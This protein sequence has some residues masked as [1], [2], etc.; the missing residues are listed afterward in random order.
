GK[1]IEEVTA[2]SPLPDGVF[3]E[4][5]GDG[6][7]GSY[8]ARQN[9][10]SISFTGSTAVGKPLY[11]I[12]AEKLIHVCL[13][14]GGSAPGIIFEDAELEGAVDGLYFSRFGNCGQACDALKRLIVHESRFDEVVNRFKEYLEA[15]KVGDPQDESTEVGPLVAKRQLRLLAAQVRDAIRKG[16][17]VATGGKAPKGLKG[18]YFLPTLLTAVTPNMRVWQEE[19]FG[20]VLPVVSFKTE[21]E[22]IQLANDTKYGLGS[23]IFTKD[24]DR[25]ARVAGMLEAG[26]VSVNN[27]TYLQPSSPFGGY[28]Q[29]GIGREHGKFG[30]SDV[31]QVKVVATEK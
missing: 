11:K 17:G 2:K 22:A 30:F 29:S 18:A 12:A 6:K 14:L 9:I 19:V 10:N 15:R 7:V 31:S 3:N 8:L 5:Y 24:K 21:E 26:M 16:A 4:V 27:V 23:Y 25:A 28:K 1:A 20:P 13:E